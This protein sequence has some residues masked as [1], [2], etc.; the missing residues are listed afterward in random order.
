VPL[1]SDVAGDHD[2]IVQAKGAFD[3]TVAGLQQCARNGIRIEIRVVLHALTI[4]RLTRLM[5]YIYRNISFAEHIALMGLEYVGYTPR[6]IGELWIDPFEYQD[7]LERAVQ[8]LSMR[9]MPVSIYN[10]QLCILRP[11]L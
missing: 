4:P 5:E 6:N 10:H 1:Y 9:D 8:Y 2:Y 3:Q 7:E 11:S